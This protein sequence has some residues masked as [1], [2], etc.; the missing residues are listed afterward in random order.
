LQAILVSN[1]EE[2]EQAVEELL[3]E[4]NMSRSER[5]EESAARMATLR[6]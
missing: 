2:I 4:Y 6:D 3:D 1:M 5:V